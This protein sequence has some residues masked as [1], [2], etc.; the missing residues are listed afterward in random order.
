MLRF[1]PALGQVSSMG[2]YVVISPESRHPEVIHKTNNGPA[3]S[4]VFS[5]NV[6]A[7]AC[8]IYAAAWRFC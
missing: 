6:F 5:K 3:D 8:Q 2:D 7:A 4:G 1:N